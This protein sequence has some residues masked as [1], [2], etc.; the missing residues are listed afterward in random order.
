MA[1]TSHQ[2][3]RLT[4]DGRDA[5]A[6]AY[7]ASDDDILPPLMAAAQFDA[8]TARQITALARKLAAVARAGR[9]SQTFGGIDAFLS[10]YGL[11][12]EE[13]VILMCLAEA[14]LRIPDAETAD[15]LIRDRIADGNWARH[16]GQ[17]PSLLVNASTWALMLTGEVIELGEAAAQAPL[18][19]L[20]RLAARVGEPVIREALRH[21]MRILGDQFVLGRSIEEAL[22]R[23][24][25][26]AEQGYLFS[27][28]MLGEA[29]RTMT[30]AER[31]FEAY[32]E[33]LA[34]IG[35]AAG[36]LAPEPNTGAASMAAD[37][38]YTRPG[39]SVKLSALHP[40]FEAAKR[41][42]LHQE[43]APKL[44]QLAR[45]AKAHRLTLTIDAEEAER[46]DITLDLFARIFADEAL[47]DWP[48]LGL[49]VQA[50]GKRALPVLCWL[51]NLSATYGRKIP[52]RLVKGAYWDA[53]IKFAQIAGLADYPVFTRKS[54]TDVSWLACMR[55]LLAAPDAFYPQLATHN[56]YS[57]AAAMVAGER[58]A[59]EKPFAFEFQR[60]H[61]MGAALY[62]PV[63]R[64]ADGSQ[65]HR[66][67]IYAPVG[68][69]EDLLAYL[70]R[71]LLENGANTSFVNR[72]ADDA[73]PLEE[74]IRD[75]LQRLRAGRLLRN[76]RIPKPPELYQPQRANSQGLPLWEAGVRTALQTAIE[77]ALKQGFAAAA[78]V[79][80]Q[81]QQTGGA[82][83]KVQSP[84]DHRL[85]VGHVRQATAADGDRA[86][87]LAVA[88]QP[89]WDQSGGAVRAARLEAAADLFEQPDH[90]ARLLAVMI[91]ETG[92]TLDNALADLREAVDFLR[93]Y[94]SEARRLFAAPQPLPGPT[95]ERNSLSLHG[96]GV[97]AC[98]SPWNFP[99]AIF[100][101]QVAA[102][103]AAG[104]AVVAKP[105]EAASLTA[106]EAV[107]LLH[108]AGIPGDVL[109]LLPG[110]GSEIGAQLIKDQRIAG[111]AF[112]GG[113]H[114]ARRI[115]Q[116]LAARGGPMV[117]LIAETG[118]INTM[119]VDST[120][121]PEQVVRDVVRSAFDSAG[122]RCSALRLLCLQQ[123]I[124]E[125]VIDMLVGAV[126]E[127]SLG[128]PLDY[129]TDI[130]PVISAAAAADL[131]AHKAHMRQTARE[132][133]DLPVPKSCAHGS[134]VGPAVY[135]ID[136]IHQVRRE[137]FGPILHV[138][139]FDG[140]ALSQ[141]YEDINGLGYGLT[142][143]L[144]SRIEAMADEVAAHV[145]VGNFYVNRNQIGAV[146]GVQPFGGEGL[147]G[148]GP[149][150]G[151]PHYLLAFAVERV[152]TTD[153]TATGG[154][155][156][157][158]SAGTE[159]LPLKDGAPK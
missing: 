39:I 33:A 110:P 104:N 44:L 65:P 11:S 48:G 14:L 40:R 8:T 148:T 119:I 153:I 92:K 133:I 45:E 149:K 74:I 100:T 26:W 85:T 91:R 49:A 21:A 88:A 139:R 27:Y 145:K 155:I 89:D 30:D 137:V 22:R 18:G 130:P 2:V 115:A 3:P 105:A 80:G 72:L 56:A 31:Y 121:L 63:V 113:N 128:D 134:F 53:E 86:L 10:E 117:P 98:I 55:F 81:V 76:P 157:L 82:V 136:H 77:A 116:T 46:L 38:L 4:I 66:C 73:A 146:V 37:V 129:A 120:A 13:G 159:S 151:G 147:S 118:G 43:L 59:E 126:R 7:L 141:L 12:N 93:Y 90:R 108:Q 123:E 114:T 28:D 127:L 50:Y 95:G 75:P 112:T 35:A 87:A 41:D 101:G 25:K 57:I 69:H 23:S 5:I 132:L 107:K 36:T 99:L 29:A 124:A 140:A 83:K 144:H 79:G 51:R 156:D 60:L 142:L 20:K 78:I 97:F 47:Q 58:M 52:V 54:A 143:G 34:P 24:E 122:Q 15:K 9:R 111:V 42:R 103:L 125:P 1:K 62:Q 158:L 109:H 32:H 16:L 96:R 67:R 94:A 152:R 61:G 138:V 131:N 17:S 84:H 150:A 64:P 70:V 71:R 19:V 6:A 135:Q 68:R 154:N 102:A 106:F